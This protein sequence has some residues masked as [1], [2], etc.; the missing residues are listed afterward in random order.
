MKMVYLAKK[1]ISMFSYLIW[2]P[3]NKLSFRMNG[4]KY[5]GVKMQR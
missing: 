3:V 1:A 4:I 2:T 5:G